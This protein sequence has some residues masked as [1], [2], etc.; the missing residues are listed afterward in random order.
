MRSPAKAWRASPARTE[1][2]ALYAR[3]D[4]LL[5]NY[6]CDASSECC[7]FGLTGR[8]PY[9]TPVERAEIEHFLAAR[10]TPPS[11]ASAPR[12]SL[13]IATSERRCAL[14][15]P[16]NRCRVYDARPLGCR[17]FFCNRARGPG[18]LPRDEI[19]RA[20]RDLAD[21]AAR[22]APGDAIGRPLSR[23]FPPSG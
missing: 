17:T 5:A 19:N 2:L 7:R 1:L 20:A 18:R 13:P 3:V 22:A 6:S 9:V 10:G 21:L 14:L 11:F 8:E 4:R 15:D 16:G 23:I 12:R